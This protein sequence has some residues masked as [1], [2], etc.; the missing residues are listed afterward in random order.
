MQPTKSGLALEVKGA[1]FRY[2]GGEKAGQDIP[3]GEIK[4]NQSVSISLGSIC[5]KHYHVMVVVNP[6]LGRLGSVSHPV[7][8]EPEEKAE[9]DIRLRTAVAGSLADMDWHVRLYLID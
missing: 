2:A 9:L 7:I 3:E 6:Q 8:V 5:P 4:A 1:N